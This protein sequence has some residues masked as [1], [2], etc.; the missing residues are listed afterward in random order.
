M[1]SWTYGMFVWRELSTSDVPEALRFYTGLL[2]W[3]SKKVEMP[4][5]AYHLLSSGEKEIGGLMALEKGV[6][7]PPYW[8]SY[9]SVPN[10]DA[11]VSSS[12]KLGGEPVW[13]PITVPD[14]GRMATVVDPRGAAFSMMR[15]FKGDPDFAPPNP[16][17]FCWEQLASHDLPT[18]KKFYAEVVEW[19]ATPFDGALE[20]FGIRGLGRQAATLVPAKA[21]LTAGWMTL[22]AVDDL[23]QACKRTEQLG[24]KL[25]G[26][27]IAVGELGS[28]VVIA[29]PQGARLGLFQ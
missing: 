16:G 2:G 7:M 6:D 18:A 10:V 28:Y 11:A 4:N 21:P 1:A 5:G 14:I 12:K 8:M 22:V 29:D 26:Q 15:S 27:P 3:Q 19:T 13:G 24:G 20:V 25:L 9:V 23:Q 17:E